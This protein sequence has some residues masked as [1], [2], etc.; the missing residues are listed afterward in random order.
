MARRR[1]EPSGGPKRLV[2]AVPT[3]GTPIVIVRGG[4]VLAPQIYGASAGELSAPFG[5]FALSESQNGFVIA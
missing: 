5:E 1:P 4:G 2:T 3:A